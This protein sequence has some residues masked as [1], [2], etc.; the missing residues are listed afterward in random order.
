MTLK[1]PSFSTS[2]AW[3]RLLD[4]AGKRVHEP[5]R[6]LNGHFTYQERRLPEMTVR[7]DSNG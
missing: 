7:L 1:T 6:E 2:S 5:K 4:F 3:D